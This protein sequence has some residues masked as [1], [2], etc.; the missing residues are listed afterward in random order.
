M[1]N[2]VQLCDTIARWLNESEPT[3]P[4][5]SA[6]TWQTFQFACRVHGVAPLLYPR[7][8]DA[9]WLPEATKPW[10]AGQYQLNRQRLAKMQAELAAIL[11]LFHQQQIPVMPLKGSILSAAYYAEA[12]LR[13]MAD[14]DLLIQPEDFEP[15]ARLLGQLGYEPGVVHWKHT[16]FC[17]P[18]NRQV[19]S[20][21]AEHP[22]NP[23]KIEVHLHCR[24]TFGGPTVELTGL[25]WR[26]AAPGT[27][28]GQPAWLPRPDALWLHLLVHATYHMWQGKGRLIHL[29]D[30]ALLLPHLGKPLTFLNSVEARFTYP[31]LAMLKKY[32]PTSL[33]Q[34]LLAAQQ[35]RLSPSFRR[36]AEA[37]D[38]VNTSHLNPK[39][40][41]LY[42]LKALRFSEGRPHEVA[43]ALRFALL[44]DLKEIALD[45]P[46]LVQSRVPWL[47]YF[48]LPL[49]WAKRYKNVS[50]RR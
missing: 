29:V 21:S 36:W 48:L 28:L 11:V 20:T 23:R 14:L 18:D 26:D 35:A 17:Q 45:H 50:T 6:E 47:A 4:D 42:L 37:L 10:L 43:Q 5:W 41:G 40:P 12:A 15:S 19:V 9:P 39:P 16:E 49:D 1:S 2:L 30:L 31:A 24:E 32:F 25:L 22:D 13:P 33:D 34:T 46:R 8:A 3:N 7:L 27:L 44:P 38:L